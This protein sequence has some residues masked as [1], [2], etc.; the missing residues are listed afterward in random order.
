MEGRCSMRVTGFQATVLSFLASPYLQALG[1]RVQMCQHRKQDAP[2]CCCPSR[3][4]HATLWLLYVCMHL[5]TR[6]QSPHLQVAT[7]DVTVTALASPIT[8]V[9]NGPAGDVKSTTSI[10]LDATA[11]TDPDDPNGITPLSF[12]WEC[13]S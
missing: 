9:L 12:T 5:A 8:T 3:I 13:I 2:N 10:R 6:L 4:A 1:T 11:S 7:A